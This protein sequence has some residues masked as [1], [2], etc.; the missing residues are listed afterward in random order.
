MGRA[1]SIAVVVV[2]GVLVVPGCGGKTGGEQSGDSGSS[3]ADA[4]PA[5]GG[6][7][8]SAAESGGSSC[9]VLGASCCTDGTCT[10]SLTCASGSCG[11]SHSSDCPGG[12]TCTT[13]RCV[14]TLATGQS[15]PYPVAVD[16][17][18]VYWVNWAMPGGNGMNGTP[19][20]VMRVS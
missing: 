9:G 4:L 7:T 12:G 10:G 20:S 15:D 13:G 17:A 1:L 19:G 5:D 8:E 16:G 3:E 14:V 6:G 2:A 18:S 11:C